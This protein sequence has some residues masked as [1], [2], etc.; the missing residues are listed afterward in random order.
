MV[1]AGA[2][3]TV[4]SLGPASG[5]RLEVLKDEMAAPAGKAL[6]R[7]IQASLK[8]DMVTVTYERVSLL[9]NW[10]SARSRRT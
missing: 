1:S 2:N 6:V 4:A 9:S 10:P 7:V 8:Q 5:R 3:Y